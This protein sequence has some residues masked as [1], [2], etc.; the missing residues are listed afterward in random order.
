MKQEER[1]S[2]KKQQSTES[3][4]SP[5]IN[6]SKAYG[7]EKNYSGQHKWDKQLKR[8]ISTKSGKVVLIAKDYAQ[9]LTI[10]NA[11]R[12]YRVRTF[13][14]VVGIWKGF[15][16]EEL[17]EMIINKNQDLR[18]K[19]GTRFKGETRIISRPTWRDGRHENIISEEIYE[20]ITRTGL[21]TIDREVKYLEEA[22]KVLV[23]Y[24]YHSFK[25]IRKY[26]QAT[27]T[28]KHCWGTIS[29][30][31]RLWKSQGKPGIK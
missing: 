2:A 3:M 29:R 24:N 4:Q 19:F 16:N 13:F 28:C 21:L 27:Q 18:I 5:T 31:K 10:N 23:C 26:C 22:P 12:A 30:R 25:H 6:S 11:M 14:T 1:Y 9:T 7:A 8:I 15:E 20:H 17:R